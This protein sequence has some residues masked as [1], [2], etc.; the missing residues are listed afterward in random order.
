MEC[1]SH[2]LSGLLKKGFIQVFTWLLWIKFVILFDALSIK[3]QKN[4]KEFQSKIQYM[5]KSMWTAKH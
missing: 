2:L 1:Y 5:A 4:V 3:C